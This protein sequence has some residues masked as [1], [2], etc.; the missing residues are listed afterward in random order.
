[1]DQ[2][3]VNT[4][5]AEVSKRLEGLDSSSATAAAPAAVNAVKTEK[6]IK[7]VKPMMDGKSVTEFIGTAKGDTIGLVIANIDQSILDNMKVEKKYRSL[8]IISDR[9]GAGPQIFAADEAVK[10]SNVDIISIETPRDTKG[11]AGHG[12]LIIF[13]ADDVSDCRRAVQVALNWID[14]VSFGDVYGNEA[15]HTE[16]QYTARASHAINM[17][18]GAPVGAACGILVGAPAGIG[19]VMA[20]A[21]VKAANI[22]VVLYASPQNGL[23]LTNE[24]VLIFTGDSGAVKQSVIAAREVGNALLSTLGGPPEN[25]GQSYIY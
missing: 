17:A 12:C 23:S 7:E 11:G 9:T 20:D 1:M 6:D 22:D 21:A 5:I 14:T 8:G 4:I 15:G 24:V 10:A 18:W 2:D 13:G 25:D 19:V 3:Y 16:L